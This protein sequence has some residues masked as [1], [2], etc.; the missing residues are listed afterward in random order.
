MLLKYLQNKMLHETENI[1]TSK[2][3]YRDFNIFD[4]PKPNLN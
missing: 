3:L 1:D 2:K 4:I